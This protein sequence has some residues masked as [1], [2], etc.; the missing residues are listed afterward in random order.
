M[1]TGIQVDVDRYLARCASLGRAKNTVDGARST[2]T[3]F[4]A[5][6]PVDDVA[7]VTED[8]IEDFLGVD[9]AHLKPSSRANARLRL[10]SFFTYLHRRGRVPRHPV[11]A[12]QLSRAPRPRPTFYRPEQAA[13]L[14]AGAPSSQGRLLVAL[15]V[16]HGQRVSSVCQLRWSDV[17]LAQA[18]VHYPAVKTGEALTLPLDMDT[19]KLLK[20]SAAIAATGEEYVFPAV[21][22]GKHGRRHLSYTGARLILQEACRRAG[23]PYRGLHELRRTCVTTLLRAGVP[24]HVVSKQVAG[25]SSVATTVRSYAGVDDD[26][27]GAALRRLPY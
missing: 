13:A 18:V 27:I 26:D 21:R 25:H 11:E 1:G 7:C 14:I 8:H 2:L 22:V 20:A 15:L 9:L 16:R 4:A 24:L 5:T 19:A 6:C 12:V 10:S 23:V 3:R 17:D